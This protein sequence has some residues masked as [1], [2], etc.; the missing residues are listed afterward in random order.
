MSTRSLNGYP[1]ERPGFHQ[2]ESILWCLAWYVLQGTASW[3]EGSLTEVGNKKFGW[4]LTRINPEVIPDG[5]RPGAEELWAPLAV[6]FQRWR[7]HE[8]AIFLLK[9]KEYSD[10]ENMA[11]IDEAI[12]YFTGGMDVW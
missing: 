7:K 3:S 9:T 12:P 10:R 6:T 2:V 1:I 5:L 11:V 8:E 4:V